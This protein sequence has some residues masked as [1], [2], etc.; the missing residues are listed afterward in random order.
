MQDGESAKENGEDTYSAHAF[1]REAL[2]I[3]IT[4]MMLDQFAGEW[5][6]MLRQQ[7][8]QNAEVEQLRSINKKLSNQVRHLESSLA[9]INQEHCELVKQVVATRLE[10]EE[11]EDELVRVKMAL[12]QESLVS[13]RYRFSALTMLPCHQDDRAD[14]FSVCLL[15]ISFARKDVAPLPRGVR[16]LLSVAMAALRHQGRRKIAVIRKRPKHPT[17][18][19]PS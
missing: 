8:A 3:K 12:A 17:S 7:N 11:L 13:L 2:Q 4:P 1:V 16:N 18:E 15:S 5:A 14:A 19:W 10:K 9:Q 6:E